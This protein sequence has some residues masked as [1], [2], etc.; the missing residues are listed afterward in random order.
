MSDFRDF[1]IKQLHDNIQSC[2]QYLDKR[3]YRAMN[4]APISNTIII[5]KPN[6][7][8]AHEYKELQ[9]HVKQLQLKYDEVCYK[10][11]QLLTNYQKIKITL[12]LQEEEIEQQCELIKEMKLIRL[13]QPQVI[14]IPVYEYLR[15]FTRN[16]HSQL[17]NFL[18][19]LMHT[20]KMDLSM[21]ELLQN[22]EKYYRPQNKQLFQ[23]KYIYPK[24]PLKKIRERILKTLPDQIV[25]Q[26]LIP[27]RSISFQ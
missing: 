24:V 15:E 17:S 5:E 18:Q 4:V 21:I 1:D 26:N 16:N 27:E 10:Y 8:I 22:I 20:K 7:A 11:M 13:Q 25:S 9:N 19:I 14:Q 3:I 2:F 23:D 12:K 6:T